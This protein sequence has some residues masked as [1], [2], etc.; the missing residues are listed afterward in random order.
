[1]SSKSYTLKYPRKRWQRG[2]IRILGRLAMPLLYRLEFKGRENFP[3]SGPLIVVG[4]HTAAMEA[5][6]LAV[7]TPWQVEMMGAADIPAEKITEVGMGFFGMIPVHRGD[8][9]RAALRQALDV[10]AQDGVIGIFPEGGFW[11]VGALQPQPGVAWLSYRSGAPVLPIGFSDTTGMLNAGLRLERPLLKMNVGTPLLPADLPEGMPRK[12]Y[13]R[14][15]ASQV[16][17]AVEALIP[18][19]DRRGQPTIKDER[20]DLDVE[21]RN[22]QGEVVPLPPALQ[23]KEKAA[24]SKFFHRPVILKIFRSNLKMPV[25]TLQR[26]VERPTVDKIITGLRPI[27]DYLEHENPYLLT[28]RFGNQ[29]GLAMQAGLKQM[30]ALAEW[31]AQ[32][33]YTLAI[34]PIRRYYSPEEAREIVEMEQGIYE[35]WM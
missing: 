10:L 31:V 25:E 26:L 28:Y 22:T 20:F 2:L 12:A 17:D 30:L 11:E 15:Y 13:F 34:K 16:M 8:F 6:L 1:M 35:Q 24:L 33:G 21:V 5:V 9:D 27:L 29:G 32:K 14:Q 7:Y 23:I 4:N 18:P 3:D 19:E